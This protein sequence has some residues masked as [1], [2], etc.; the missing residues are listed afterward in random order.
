MTDG[1]DDQPVPPIE[2]GP[3][4]NG[5]YVPWP[6]TEVTREAVRR[7][8]AI[9]DDVAPRHNMSRR[10]FLRS[11]CGT[12][13]ALFVLAAC[14]S[15]SKKAKG[16][17][18]GGTFTVP[19][20]A[21]TDPA[22][23]REVLGGDE[24]VFDVQTHL[25]EY[26]PGAQSDFGAGFPYFGCGEADGLQ[27]FGIDHWF[28]EVFV[29]SDTTMAVISA[30]PLLT[31]PNPLSIDVMEQARA[32]AKRVC[33][34]DKRVFLHGQVNPN[35]GDVQRELDHMRAMAAAHPI[36][37]WK[38]YTHVPGNRGWWLD[39]HDPDAVR[40]GQAFVDAVREI[41][42]PIVCVHK[43]LGASSQYSSPMDIG[44]VAKA[45]PDITF[46]VYHSG[47]D[48][49]NEG[50]YDAGDADHGVNRLI[51]SLDGAGIAPHANVYAELGSTWFLA[52]RDPTQAAHVLGKLLARVGED[53]VLWGT[54]SI[55]YGSPQPQIE[56]LRTF[57]ISNELQDRFHYP[58]LT[59]SLRRKV[60]GANAA[61][62]YGVA[63]PVRQKCNASP[64]QLA[65]LRAALPP[66]RAYGPRTI[67]EA[68]A[69]MREHFVA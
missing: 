5:E 4:S 46:V 19:R 37:A 51:A 9:T 8:R 24:F 69:H 50:P 42:P 64:D 15:E 38:V 55:W 60:F 45:N 52:M 13:A 22:H 49:P 57:S 17:S 65:Q 63:A 47:Y 44:P 35:V 21:T 59:D 61:R 33:G 7:L 39:D 27:C 58:E 10:D 2:L 23:A 53:R 68:T 14:A 16:Q 62:L 43:G 30:V 28:R 18:P 41:G 48:G 11:S 12:A 6:P 66:P 3:I 34:D 40:C 26:A 31:D 67:A 36:A 1:K 32:A 25:L 29:R 20:T 56:A 54:D